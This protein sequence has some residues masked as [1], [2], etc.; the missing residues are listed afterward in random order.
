MAEK[1]RPSRFP[2]KNLAA[3]RKLVY[4]G[5]TDADIAEAFEVTEQTVNNWKIK[6][7]DFFES[8]KDWK[9]DA[10][11]NVEKALY[12]RAIGCDIP[13]DKV[14]NNNGE[15]LIVEGRKHY[16]PDTA[17]AFIWLQNRKPND[18]RKEQ[19]QADKGAEDL[20]AALD[21]LADKL[22]S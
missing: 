17:A 22:P 3:I 5:A 20:A 1:G 13:E 11:A 6:H 2:A 9:K 8:L 15:P 4:M 10:D 14:F 21:K 18:W 16:P 12:Q 19:P 7:P